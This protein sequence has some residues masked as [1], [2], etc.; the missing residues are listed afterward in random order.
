VAYLLHSGEFSKEYA[1]KYP[2][3]LCKTSGLTEKTYAQIAE[4]A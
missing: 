3:L 4:G 2:Q 1:Q